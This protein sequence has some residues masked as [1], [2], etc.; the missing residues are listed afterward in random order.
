MSFKVSL[1]LNFNFSRPL[2]NRS[3]TFINAWELG[4]K[5]T[6]TSKDLSNMS[7]RLILDVAVANL[8][9]NVKL[10][11]SVYSVELPKDSKLSSFKIAKIN[12]S[13]S[14]SNCENF[15]SQKETVYEN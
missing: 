3:D 10:R 4:R 7:H 13:A 12:A 2:V 14:H 11:A 1:F 6:L 5:G 8:L 9:I 15:F